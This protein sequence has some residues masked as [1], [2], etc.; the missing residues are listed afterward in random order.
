M[1]IPM[2]ELMDFA[3]RYTAA[4]CSQDAAR[5]AAFYAS[6][7]SL[8]INNDEPAVGRRAITEATQA[9]MAAFPDLQ[10]TMEGVK[11][12]GDEAEYHWTLTGTNT[13]HGGKGNRV[14]IS[15]YEVW[16][17]DHDGLIRSSRGRFD[18]GDY[19]RQLAL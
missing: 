9:F 5:V 7:G 10:V 17:F 4:W 12:E 16:E 11:V 14:R 3:A 1:R 8:T 6:D 19:R 13:G 2:A 15:G 18:S